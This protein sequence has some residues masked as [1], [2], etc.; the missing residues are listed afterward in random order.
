MGIP[1]AL[2]QECESGLLSSISIIAQLHLA[3]VELT[4][5]F[6]PRVL[7]SPHYSG[8]RYGGDDV[9]IDLSLNFRSFL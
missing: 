1:F 8:Q 4:S 3:N 5:S 2:D 6:G 7:C 9:E